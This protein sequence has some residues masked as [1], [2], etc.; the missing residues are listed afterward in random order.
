MNKKRAVILATEGETTTMLFNTLK[1][2]FDEV[3]VV[4]EN[5]ISKKV[6]L[7]SRAKKVGW[8]K[9]FG[10]VLFLLT[11]PKILRRL[12]KKRIS[13]IIVS[14]GLSVS[15]I[16]KSN[17]KI[18]NTINDEFVID[19]INEVNPLTIFV[20]GTRIISEKIITRIHKPLINIHTGITPKYRGVHGGYWALY[21]NEPDLFGS[22]LH[23]IDKG[24]D[25][26]GVIDQE[27]CKV[28]KKDN[29]V[30]YPFLQFALGRD[31]LVKHISDIKNDNT[32]LKQPIVK[33]S[34][35]YYHPTLGEYLIK[36]ALRKVK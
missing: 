16:P 31:L 5:K 21:N 17:I 30:T 24:I 32:I 12:S 10:Q 14:N 9:V 28:T 34:E 7:K 6:I 19:I 23:F 13:E 8:F 1:L 26:G 4:L 3:I 18:I 15:A 36:R 25:T 33:E 35:L 22:T 29:F 2:H 27:I 20:N 11:I